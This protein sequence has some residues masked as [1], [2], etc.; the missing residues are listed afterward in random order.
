MK[1]STLA[2]AVAAG[3]ISISLSTGAF[4][5]TS[6]TEVASRIV[7][8]EADVSTKA[9]IS[10]VEQAIAEISLTPGAKGDPGIDGVDGVDGNNGTNGTNGIDGLDGAKADLSGIHADIGAINKKLVDKD[11]DIGTINNKLV[12][13]DAEIVALQENVATL[14][15]WLESLVYVDDFT[16][17]SASGL[18]LASSASDWSCVRDNVTGHV[19]EVKTDSGL[20]SISNRYRWGGIG[21]EQVGTALYDDWNVLVNG[22]HG[23]C[24]YSDW[25]VP[26][27]FELNAASQNGGRAGV[28]NLYFN[29]ASWT[30]WSSSAS[31]NYADYAWYVDFYYGNSDYLNRY[32]NAPVRLVRGGQ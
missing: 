28:M 23:L 22:S 10:D 14:T 15:T 3:V 29:H 26:N 31:E 5:R 18:P 12:D 19:W 16:K 13:K 21:A 17:I 11:A 7:A 4:A 8:L 9:S 25:R 32:D 27:R 2:L 30:F 1:K 24:G 20:H 6:I